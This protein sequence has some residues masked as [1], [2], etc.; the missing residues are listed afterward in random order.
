[1]ITLY[2]IPS[3]APTSSWSINLLKARLSLNYKRVP[4]VTEWVE[5]PDIAALYIKHD[6]PAALTKA[7]GSPYYTL[8]M[9]HDSATGATIADSLQIAKYLDATYP[10]TPRLFPD[11][12]T[13]GVESEVEQRIASL[14][15]TV[16]KTVF[17]PLWP[18]IMLASLRILTP[19][20]RA[21]FARVRAADVL[22]SYG[23]ASLEDIQLTD[24]EVE[25]AWKGIEENFTKTM[26]PVFNNPGGSSDDSQRWFLGDT[27]SFADIALASAL[28]WI[29]QA[30]GSNS[31][32]WARVGTWDGG[33]WIRFI[34]AL[35]QVGCTAR[36]SH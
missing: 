9:I 18:P 26:R 11:D 35:G 14:I 20:S 8:P 7:D 5:Y 13:A 24:A 17:A 30:F 36:L 22:A 4:Y 16:Q 19:R 23:K 6:I 10:D 12:T 34:D 28:L 27:I 32:E 25:A 21:H 2:D 29:R 15:N 1:M 33:E 3:T 31:A